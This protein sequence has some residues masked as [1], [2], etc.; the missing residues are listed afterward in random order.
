VASERLYLIDGSA[1]VYRSYYAFQRNPLITAK[2]EPTSV[3][4][5]FAAAILRLVNKENPTRMAVLFD[6]GKPTFRKKIYADYKATR[7]PMP[8]DMREQLPRLDEM[9]ATMKLPTASKVGF[10]ADDLIATL[11]RQATAAGWEV[12][13]VSGDK[14]LMQL[15][16]EQVK[17]LNL[18]KTADAGE[19]FDREAVKKKMGVYPEQV[20]EF[21]ALTGDNS[22]NIPGVPGVG[23]KT[24]VKLLEEYGSIE[25]IFANV[26]KI[27][28]NKLRE[29][30]AASDEKVALAKRLVALDYEVEINLQLEDL[31][32]PEL[33]S[34]EVRKLF[35]ELE[36][37]ALAR[38]LGAPDE[39]SKIPELKQDYQTVDA[40]PALRKLAKRMESVG[41]FAFDTETDGLD[42]INCKLVGIS[43]AVAAGEAYYLPLA[44]EEG[45]NLDSQTCLEILGPVFAD[46][47]LEKIAQNF[48]FDYHVMTS[49]GY[50]LSNF[51]H[52][53]MLASYILD[54][55]SRQ[56][57]LDF[58]TLKYF[59]YRMQP[60]RD[61]I[62]TG[63]KQ[64]TFDKVPID[65]AT[66]YSGEDADFTFR[67]SEKLEIEVAAIGA[68]GLLH[69]IELPLARVLAVMERNGVR[70][71]V[72]FLQ[73][74][75]TE[76]AADLEGIV[77]DIHTLAGHEF[78]VNSPAQ[79]ATVLFEEIGLK[80]L[81]KTA[82]KSG[83]STDVNVLTE[84][85]RYHDLPQRV[86]DYR[87]LQKLKSTYVDTLPL[88]VNDQTGRV[89]TSYNQAVAATGRLSSTD[90]NLQNIP[91]KTEIGSQIRKAFIPADSD[92]LLMAADYSQ[93]EL[94]ILAHYCED[95]TLVESFRNREDIHSRTASTVY[96]VDLGDVTTEMR[97]M[98]KTANFAVIYGVSAFGLAQQ[99]DMTIAE[100]R[101]FIDLYYA[102]Y[103]RIKEFTE[104][105]IEK[106]RDQGYVTTLMGRRRN[107]PEI[108]SSNRQ[109]RQFAERTAVNTV[110][111]GTAADMIKV[112]MI[113]IQRE[114]NKMKS[115]MIMQV[116][117]ELVFDMPRIEEMKL[118]A[119][120]RDKMESCVELKVP[121]EVDLGI[122]ENWLACK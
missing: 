60:I 54:P 7:K 18:R 113:E 26:E 118:T 105:V 55:G 6:T 107:L 120:V 5:G 19:L 68:A 43:V 84:L 23:P 3:V 90:P 24:A 32:L 20:H 37:N 40:E 10:E 106:A 46:P 45:K 116:H 15:V 51:D 41:C 122:G 42:A 75:S 87:H 94:R 100:S 17:L 36:F 38:E 82:T 92:H 29:N 70:I 78:N 59:N 77:H 35:L 8:D 67:L 110:I 66:F 89:H 9:L 22:D 27:K 58:L 64:I 72:G 103:P 30:I 109:L 83:Y 21:L 69:D 4:F 79:L 117:D 50:K 34:P 56:H 96:G 13:I 93:V 61:L 62:G 95:P 49:A 119:L 71:D 108:N 14:D 57:G 81:R 99:S 44:H 25:N 97:R 76:M 16:G 111:Q 1:L 48:K 28:Q 31:Q 63:K 12:V 112:A 86:L 33:G 53:P 104:S 47:R 121:L 65:K 74:M 101:E 80:P 91:I 114:L 11:C 115:L 39:P 73:Q 85:A 52:D 102:R 88:L 2:G 98:A